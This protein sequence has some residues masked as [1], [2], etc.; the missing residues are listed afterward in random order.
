[1]AAGQKTVK[2]RFTGD[3]SG[4]S[5]AAKSAERSMKQFG[6]NAG[7]ALKGLGNSVVS[8]LSSSGVYGA[9][10]IVAAVAAAA[11]LAGA[12]LTAGL[13]LGLGG[14][15]LALGI[16]AAM[17]D[18]AVKA[19]FEP[20]KKTGKEIAD[21]FGEPFKAPLIRAAKTFNDALKSM[22]PTFDAIAKATAPLIDLLAPA[23]ASMAKSSLPGI[24]SAIKASV[25]LFQVL[26]KKAPEFGAAI[27]KFLDAVAKGGPGAQRFL[28]DILNFLIWI[29]PK[30]GQLIG[31]L[32]N[33]YVDW[34]NGVIKALNAAKSAWNGFYSFF[35]GIGNRIGSA[36]G[37]VINKFN[38]FRS[39]VAGV[40][41]SI[42]GTIGNAV[43]RIEG[44][45]NRLKS[46]ASSAI[47]FSIGGFSIPGLSGKRAGGGPVGAGRSYLVGEKGPEILTMG[48]SGGNITPNHALGGGPEVIE[49][50]L[51]LGQGIQ[52]V[53]SINLKEHDRNIKRG[54]MAKG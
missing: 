7:G 28:E 41:N 23:L 48:S 34:R 45:W 16:K 44:W 49:L 30:A 20:L 38:S 12:A 39:R 47:N 17:S 46:L 10:A 18:P 51:D 5:R 50:H 9:A 11:P 6:D 35:S 4:V 19:A 25:P 13:L 2:I 24:Q 22:K 14:G 37:S 36:L 32:A 40:W 21:S 26:A 8:T 1:M 27:S 52:Q 53:I 33:R 43:N 42:V 15:A 3:A 54:V 29:L 31:W